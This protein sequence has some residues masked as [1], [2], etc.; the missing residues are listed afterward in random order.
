MKHFSEV[1]IAVRKNRF[2][3]HL[4]TIWPQALPKST[5]FQWREFLLPL[6]EGNELRYRV[7]GGSGDKC[8]VL[9]HGLGGDWG[10]PEA[11]WSAVAALQSGY[12]A[13]EVRWARKPPTHA[14]QYQHMEQ[15]VQRLKSQHSFRHI[16]LMGFSLGGSVMLNWG[17]RSPDPVVKRLIAVCTPLNLESTAKNLLTGFNRIYDKRF[18]KIFRKW[19]PEKGIP[20]RASVYEIDELFT[21]KIHGFKNRDDYYQTCSAEN[22]LDQISIPQIYLASEND[23]LVNVQDYQ[24][25][26]ENSQRKIHITKF[27]G[28]V[29]YGPSMKKF[30]EEIT[31]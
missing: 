19:I 2:H 26:S 13:V 7:T 31:L 15:V 3:G 6:P 22:F 30:V 17:Y 14:G 20:P 21:A 1:D 5:H 12:A 11:L 24:R 8:W 16:E 27:G 4:Q 9:L 29:G 23:P 25:L 10:G 18:N 28:H